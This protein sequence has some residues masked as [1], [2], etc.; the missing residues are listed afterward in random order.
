MSEHTPTLDQVR[1]RFAHR[2]DHPEGSDPQW[3]DEFDRWLAQY[4]R[5]LRQ[6][7]ALNDMTVERDKLQAAVDA[8]RGLHK[9]APP[10]LIDAPSVCEACSDDEREVAHPCPTIRALDEHL[11]GGDD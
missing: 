7:I 5:Q 9:E 4:E 1:A 11:G 8:V 6:Q 3:A 10:Y 2:P